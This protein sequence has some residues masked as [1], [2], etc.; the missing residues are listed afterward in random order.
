MEETR[1]VAGLAKSA[2]GNAQTEP[3][4]RRPHWRMANLQ[5]PC[6]LRL[7]ALPGGMPVG[8]TAI[9]PQALVVAAD[10][11]RHRPIPNGVA[12]MPAPAP[13]PKR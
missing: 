4:S 12:R 5:R 9:N 2:R 8:L 10:V 6:C 13:E 3:A 11:P 7:M 1:R